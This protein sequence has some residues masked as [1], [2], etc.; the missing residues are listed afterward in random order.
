MPARRTVSRRGNE[1]DAM[2]MAA[3]YDRAAAKSN[4]S[5]ARAAA[6]KFLHPAAA[7][8]FRN[9]KSKS[10]TRS[11]NLARAPLLPKLV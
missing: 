1:P 4:K 3:L 7:T 2:K 10:G 6:L 5:R 9:F 8:S 11:V